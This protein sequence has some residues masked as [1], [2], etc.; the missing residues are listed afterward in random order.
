MHKLIAIV[1]MSLLCVSAAAQNGIELMDRQTL[2][3][4]LVD[5]FEM[6]E[7]DDDTT[8]DW[9]IDLGVGGDLHKFWFRT[10][11]S[12]AA[13]TRSE[14]QV[15]WGKAI[16]PF[17]DLLSGV[18]RTTGPEGDRNWAALSI[19]GLARNQFD[20][21]AGLFVAQGGQASLRVEAEY[22]L[23]ITQRLI[24]APELEVVGYAKDEARWQLGSGVGEI[25]LDA[26]LRYEWKREVAPYVGIKWHRL[27]GQTRE[28][29]KLAGRDADDT[30]LVIGLRAWF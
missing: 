6:T 13:Q 24:L 12:D 3:Y 23:Y 19:R 9:N 16:L 18:R 28:F 29:E 27:L 4:L 25:G 26:R 5:E 2:V 11:G 20:V 14:E 30:M 22:E 21:E 17:W 10:R 15:A 7:V 1:V 8:L